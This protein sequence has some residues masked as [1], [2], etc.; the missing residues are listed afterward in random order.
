MCP[1]NLVPD[2]VFADFLWEDMSD[3]ELLREARAVLEEAAKD[4]P[5]QKP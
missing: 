3:E 4:E 1:T 2:E 5:M